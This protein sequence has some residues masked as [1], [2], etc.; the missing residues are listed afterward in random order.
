MKR[1]LIVACVVLVLGADRKDAVKEELKKLQGTWEATK[2]TY[3]GDK[4]STEDTGNISM[5]VKGDLATVGANKKIK[6]EYGKVKLT[7]DPAT[8]PKSIDVSITLGGQKGL[9]IEGIYKL[10]KDTL[11]ICAKVLGM[12]RPSKFESPGGESIVLIV[13]KKKE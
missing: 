6:G 8:T 1:C 5:T 9:T 4:L 3:N 13:L 2:V 12:D 7:V 11:T 10:E